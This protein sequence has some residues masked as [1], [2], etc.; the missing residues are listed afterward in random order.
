MSYL[1]DLDPDRIPRHVAI[2]MDGNGR[3]AAQRGLPRTKGHEQGEQALYD[4]VE[5]GLEVGLR[6]LTVYAFSTENW[7]RPSDEVKFLMNFNRLLIRKRRND[8]NERGVRIRFMGRRDRRLPRSVQTEMAAAEAMTE[9]NTR[10]TLVI[11][12]NYGGRAEIVDAVRSLVQD[13]P[14]RVDGRAIGKR[15]YLPDVPDP[16]L[17]IRTSGEMRISNFLV[18]QAAYAELWFTPVLWPDFGREQLF[19]AIRDYQKRERRFGKLAD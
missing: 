14:G 1:N 12:L 3:W 9:G 5:G 16:D 7:A 2:V 4:V 11:A 10:M 6:Y 18:W 8:L 19:E 17:L 13:P 15:L